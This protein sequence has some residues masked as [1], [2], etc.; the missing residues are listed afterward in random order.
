MLDIDTSKTAVIHV[1]R[2]AE[3]GMKEHVRYLLRYADKNEFN[4]TLITYPD[5]ELT[6]WAR[7]NQIRYLEAPILD[8]LRPLMDAKAI[9]AVRRHVI[10]FCKGRAILHAHGAK[11]A[12]I[13]RLARIVNSSPL[14]TLRSHHKPI[15][16]YTI[17]GQPLRS[18]LTPSVRAAITFAERVLWRHCDA[19]IAVS[20]HIKAKFIQV[21]GVPDEKVVVIPNGVDIG[22]FEVR[23]EEGVA[24]RLESGLDPLADKVI[25]SVSRFVPEKRLDLVLEA[26]AH[27]RR[28][29]EPTSTRS[30]A[31]A[32]LDARGTPAATPASTPLTRSYA[33]RRPKLLLVGDGPL[34]KSLEKLAETLGV[35][36]DV[37]FTGTRSDVPRTLAAMDVFVLASTED[38]APLALIEAMAAGKAVVVPNTASF[39][40]VVKPP[41]GFLVRP[42]DPKALASA[43]ARILNDDSMRERLGKRA[44]AYAAEHLSALQMTKK[45]EELYRE[46]LA[47]RSSLRRW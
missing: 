44:R 12:L 32:H 2:T 9:L 7:S 15:I 23:A 42:Q 25:G 39:A 27:L 41:H 21:S 4:E 17:H 22:R 1:V 18:H 26:F 36:Q 29:L 11:A 46:L 30:D 37:V 31:K 8:G 6:R 16:V 10:G 45:T 28:S 3:G 13:A 43:L 5:E 35:R 33:I 47:R 24:F 34:R 14:G 19:F 20:E 38:G 40:E